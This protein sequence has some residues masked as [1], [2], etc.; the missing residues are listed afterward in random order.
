MKKKEHERL[1]FDA[2]RDMAKA[3]RSKATA[4]GVS[5]ADIIRLLLRKG[6]AA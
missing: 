3:I 4:D 2:P 5:M 1:T 6:L